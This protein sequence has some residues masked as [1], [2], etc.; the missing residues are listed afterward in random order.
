[1]DT[2]KDS[3]ITEDLIQLHLK[4]AVISIAEIKTKSKGERV[5]V[6]GHMDKV[7]ELK[8]LNM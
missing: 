6:R 7:S 4:P 3:H 8:L 2:S 5:S 1:M